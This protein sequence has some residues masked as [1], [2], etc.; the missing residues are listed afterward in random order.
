M[1]DDRLRCD[2]KYFPKGDDWHQVRCSYKAR[3]WYYNKRNAVIRKVCK[4]HARRYD[5]NPSWEKM[6]APH[7]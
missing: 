4:I 7:T 3:H 2:A 5:G 6:E 1:P